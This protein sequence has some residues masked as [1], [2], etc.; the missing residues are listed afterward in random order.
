MA[1]VKSV[2][3]SHGAFLIALALGLAAGCAARA[4][5]EQRP[6]AVKGGSTIEG[7]ILA[8]GGK[9]PAAASLVTAIHLETSKSYVS[10]TSASG[11]FQ[12]SGVPH[13]YYELAIASGDKL[14]V[15]AVPLVV[16]PDARIKI[17]VT[18]LETA[19]VSDTGDPVI[20]PIL[21]QPATGGAKIAGLDHKPFFK[22]PAGKATAIAG[23]VL[24]LLL[25]TH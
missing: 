3:R 23:S 17:D 5:K 9:E 25:V 24:L 4:P 12:L 19:P 2:T 14:H 10:A 16:G 18:L 15:G 20:I 7:D 6:P 1:L 8:V 22:T 11:H 21:G 13:G